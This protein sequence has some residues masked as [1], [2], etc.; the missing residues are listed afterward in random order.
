MRILKFIASALIAAIAVSCSNDEHVASNS[1]PVESSLEKSAK[2]AHERLGIRQPAAAT[3]EQ[4][5]SEFLFFG[6][7]PFFV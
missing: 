3:R 1:K 6:S 7:L 2:N 5:K 4:A